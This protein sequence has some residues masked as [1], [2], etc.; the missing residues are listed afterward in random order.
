M[1]ASIDSFLGEWSAVERAG[2][3]GKLDLLP[4]EDFDGIGPV[5][6]LVPKAE[7][8]TR[9]QQGLSYESFGLDETTVRAHGDDHHRPPHPARYRLLQPHP[10]SCPSHLR[11]CPP[12]GAMAPGQRSHELHRRH[13][14]RTTHPGTGSRPQPEAGAT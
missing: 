6:F 11:P 13:P 14:R 8:L 7:W 2:D 3:A 1:T 12:R 9:H 4:I 10:R 5:G